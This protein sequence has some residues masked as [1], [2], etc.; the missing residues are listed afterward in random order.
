MWLEY[1]GLPVRKKDIQRECR[2]RHSESKLESRA[3][4]TTTEVRQESQVGIWCEKCVQIT[5][6]ICIGRTEAGEFNYKCT[7][8]DNLKQIKF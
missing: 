6:H 7:E 3:I 8:C 4:Y 1:A 5:V 2:I